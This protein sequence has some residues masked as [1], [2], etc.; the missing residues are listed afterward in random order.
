MG[1]WGRLQRKGLIGLFILGLGIN[2]AEV[3]IIISNAN[4]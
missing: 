3:L 4:Y 2:K 1:P